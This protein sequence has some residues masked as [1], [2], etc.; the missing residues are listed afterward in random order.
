MKYYQ[1]IFLVAVILLHVISVLAEQT[2]TWGEWK[3]EADGSSHTAYCIECGNDS[4]PVK[5]YNFTITV[6]DSTARICAICGFSKGTQETLQIIP[7]ASAVPVKSDPSPQRGNLVV[8]GLRYPIKGDEHIV[9]A[10]TLVYELNGSLATFKN[11]SRISIPVEIGG[12]D[13]WELLRIAGA[14]GDDSVQ[15]AESWVKIDSAYENDI[16][17]FETKTPAL[18]IIRASI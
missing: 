2:H 4:L 12:T 5:H 10:F 8:R 17:S 9:F 3:A 18:Y 7:D 13:D 15:T 6:N 11:Q 1:K 16:L 14:S